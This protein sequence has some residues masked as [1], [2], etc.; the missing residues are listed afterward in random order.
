M[1][2]FSVQACA[3]LSDALRDL[4]SVLL[5][6]FRVDQWVPASGR[7]ELGAWTTDA[8]RKE[9]VGFGQSKRNPDGQDGDIN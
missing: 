3:W 9:E 2:A 7:F 8:A 5:W 1:L 4:N 6:D